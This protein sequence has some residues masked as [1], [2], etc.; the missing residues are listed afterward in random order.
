VFLAQKVA[1]IEGVGHSA[2]VETPIETM[3]LIEDFWK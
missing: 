2:M 3:K 1:M